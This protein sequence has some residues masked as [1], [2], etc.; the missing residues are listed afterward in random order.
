MGRLACLALATS[1][2]SFGC[3]NP[4]EQRALSL[5]LIDSF[6][7][8][9]VEGAVPVPE[10]DEE[11]DWDFGDVERAAGW[12]VA[13][14]VEGLR[15]SEGRL[16]GR[17]NGLPAAIHAERSGD[18]PND[19]LHAVEI[20]AR[21]SSGANMSIDFQAELALPRALGSIF[22]SDGT[23]LIP[24][25]EIQTYTITPSTPVAMSE[26]RHLIL[27]PSDIE[28]ADFAIESVRVISRREHLAAIPS[29]IGW[30]GLEKVFRETLVSRA[31]EVIRTPLELPE[32]PRFEVALGTLSN[33]PV[34]FSVRIAR[35]TTTQELLRRTVTRA[36][37]WEELSVNLEAHAGRDVTLEL[38]LEAAPDGTIGFWGS[39]VVRSRR[40]TQASGEVRG[41]LLVIADTLRKD[42]LQAYGHERDTAPHVSRLAAEGALFETCVPQATWTKVSVSSIMTSLYPLTHGVVEFTDRMPATAHTLAESF[43][44]HGWATLGLSSITFNGQFTN[45]HQGYE[46]FHEASSLPD[47][48]SSKTARV[49]VDRL[50]PWLEGHRDVPFFAVLHV[51][52]PHSPFHPYAPYDTLWSE[53]GDRETHDAEVERARKVIESP[54]MQRFGMPNAQELAEAGLDAAEYV[55]REQTWYDASIRAMDA[56]LGRVLEQLDQLGIAD[57]TLVAFT[58]DHGEEFLEHGRHWHGH[59]VYG[60]LARVPLILRGPRVKAGTRVSEVAESI[61]LMPTLLELAGIPP[62]E[63]GQGR[64]LVPLISGEASAR[65]ASRPAFTTAVEIADIPA[66]QLSYPDESYGVLDDGWMFVHNV[67]RPVDFPEYELYREA[68]DPL[69]QIDLAD[70]HPEIVERLAATLSGWRTLTESQKLD[71]A[72][73][74]NVSAEELERLRSLGYVN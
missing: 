53:P 70:Q 38:A 46:V 36:D 64:S 19:L 41:V 72:D 65:W 16:V 13:A 24:G 50:L 2:C 28:G 23:P 27:R 74:S 21:V 61:D 51:S 59:A 32:H 10:I 56:E 29:G 55:R 69:H 42:R 37:H 57:S 54:L 67:R 39:P 68:D 26:T 34:T 18:I 66:S 43:R 44:Q 63:S 12:K 1:V 5:R 49:H 3:V 30:H 48:L 9:T 31:P 47:D 6:P 15:V 73:L 71:E 17:T 60:E 45:L 20:R 58:S 35:G 22:P 8:A 11:P 33:A 62:V 40:T 4:G 25:D 52:D 7:S 14:G